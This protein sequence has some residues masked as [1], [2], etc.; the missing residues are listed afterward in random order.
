MNLQDG[1]D[2]DLVR[3]IKHGN[4]GAFRILYDTYY[5]NILNF[6]HTYTGSIEDAEEVTQDTFLKLWKHRDG[7]DEEMS[8]NGYIFRIAKNL[9][10]NK[11]R[12]KVMEPRYFDEIEDES[13][14]SN[15]TEEDIMLDEMQQ[16]LMKA[17]EALPPK[18][19]QIFRLSRLSGLPNKE[20][21]KRLN[22]SE[23]TVEGQMRKS[24][25]YLRSYI[26]FTTLSIV[27][28]WQLHFFI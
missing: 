17:I 3:K 2:K 25:K 24:I 28:A 7:L 4:L 11:I 20:I 18:R 21:A 22:I 23:N 19:Q 8:V 15:Q 16:L 12:K 13:V 26:E 9:T 10:L 27:L 1:I 5:T 14:F 6:S